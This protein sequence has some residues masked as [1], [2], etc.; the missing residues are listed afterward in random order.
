MQTVSSQ[1]KAESQS[2]VPAAVQLVCHAPPTWNGNLLGVETHQTRVLLRCL[3][4]CLQVRCWCVVQCGPEQPGWLHQSQECGVLHQ[5][6]LRPSPSR[7]CRLGSVARLQYSFCHQNCSFGLD[8]NP[9]SD[10]M[11]SPMET[12]DTAVA[13]TLDWGRS[14]RSHSLA[15]ARPRQPAGKRSGSSSASCRSLLNILRSWR[16][17]SNSGAK[18]ST[19]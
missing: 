10:A 15:C 6:K 2:R 14:N 18:K 4:C 3:Q 13:A 17:G 16:A 11:T 8:L 5:V 7:D 12:S 9:R 19:R 1:A